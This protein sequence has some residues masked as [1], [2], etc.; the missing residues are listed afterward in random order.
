M[1]VAVFKEQIEQEKI[2]AELVATW[3]TYY[4]L[5]K[6]RTNE[7][8]VKQSDRCIMSRESMHRYFMT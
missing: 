6:D 1:T 8:H 5:D 7:K 3:N 4:L 2:L